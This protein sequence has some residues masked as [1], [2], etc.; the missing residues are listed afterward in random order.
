ME[1]VSLTL[2]GI[3]GVA[4]SEGIKFLYAETGEL[5]KRWW[6]REKSDDAT[7][8]GVPVKIELPSAFAGQLHDPKANLAV[9]AQNEERL[10]ELAGGLS[11]YADGR[12]P[13]ELSDERLLK[14]VDELRTLLEDVFGQRITFAG[15]ARPESGSPVVR[16]SVCVD[17][18][19]GEAGGV[20]ADT[21]GGTIE[22]TAKARE[23][24]ETGSLFGAVIETKSRGGKSREGS[25]ENSDYKAR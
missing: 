21:L 14:K 19:K 7:P 8:T 6:D 5:L 10:E 17:M 3:G 20:K 13:I 24:T 12:K 4:L 18:V 16:G 15:E 2:A 23:V 22:G 25:R 9:V 11:L 1:P